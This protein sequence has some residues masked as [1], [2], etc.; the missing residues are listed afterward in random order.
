MLYRLTQEQL[1]MLI[2]PLEG[3]EKIEVRQIARDLGLAS[4][5]A[6]DSQEICWLPDG[7]YASFIEQK[8]VNPNPATSSPRMERSAA[9][10]KVC[11]TIRSDRENVS[12]SH[13]DTLSLSRRL[14][15]N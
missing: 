6:P 12:A 7:D 9:S 11:S 5:D 1:S 8:L 3:L 4:A 14:T 13:W 10:T 2:L 15:Q